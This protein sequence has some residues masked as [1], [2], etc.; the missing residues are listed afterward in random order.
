MTAISRLEG[1]FR[2][3]MRRSDGTGSPERRD[4]IVWRSSANFGRST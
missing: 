2:V 1:L 4:N 3:E